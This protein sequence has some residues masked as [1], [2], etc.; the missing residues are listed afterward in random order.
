MFRHYNFRKFD[1][2]SPL[3]VT[4]LFIFSY[5]VIGSA[6][7]ANLEEGTSSYAT[8]Q[9][10]GFIIGFVLMLIVSVIDYHIV[11]KLVPLVFLTN[12]GLL[13]AVFII[14]IEVNGA[15]R[16]I[17][18]VAGYTIQPSE[19]AKF[20]MVVVLAKYFDKFEKRI[21]NIFVLIGAAILMGVPVL[22]IAK[23]PDLSTS[24]VLIFLLAMM[25]FGGGISYKYIIAVALIA[26]PL[27]TALL[28]YIQ[29]DDQILLQDYQKERILAMINPEEYE[30][31]TA[32]QT[33]KSVQA[34]GSGQL[35]GK[36]LYQGKLNQY[37]YLSE[38]QTDF[39]FAIIGEEFGFIGCSGVLFLLLLLLIRV[40]YIA[41]D[42]QDLMGRLLV[43]GFVGIVAFH[44][45]INVGVATAIVPNTGLPLPF[46]SSGLSALW[47]NMLMLGMILN[48]SMQ[49]KISI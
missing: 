5:Y 31:S 46:V 10:Y 47:S 17:P 48:V 33:Q 1:Y 9:L 49:R 20:F 12:I 26:V 37:N 11:G 16:W 38:S 19:F 32:L 42:S 35:E 25:I 24:L 18:V 15:T 4:C 7:R 6:S 2:I 43:V 44:T 45:F 22:L 36:G 29:T 40:L 14:G 27:A 41:K 3:I 21:N 13:L 39:I 30:Q 28:A 8:K 34:I 23:Q